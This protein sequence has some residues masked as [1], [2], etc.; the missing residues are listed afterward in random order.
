MR[1]ES[2]GPDLLRQRAFACRALRVCAS[3]L[4]LGAAACSKPR[5]D[6]P[7]DA[8]HSFSRAVQKGDHQAAYARLSAETQQ[9]LKAR[10]QQLS[11]ASGGAIKDDPA[12][13]VF[14]TPERAPPLTEVTLGSQ[15]GD[16]AIL[17][18]SSGNLSAQIRMVREPGGWK[19]ELSDAIR[20]GRMK[21]S[22]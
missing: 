21:A 14:S 2:N 6:S 19:V 9:L 12:A 17:N 16:R 5:W 20:S 22:P 4:V 13:L 8:Y 11:Q 7:V 10:A 18:A 3:L 1:R 15:D